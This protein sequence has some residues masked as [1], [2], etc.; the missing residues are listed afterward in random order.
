LGD[1]G[2][3][4]NTET[5]AIPSR[6][7]I[8]FIAVLIA[9]S[10]FGVNNCD[11]SGDPPTTLSMEP[12]SSCV[13]IGQSCTLSVMVDDAVDSLSCVFCVVSFDPE[14]VS[15]TAAREG[16]LYKQAPHPTFFNWELVAP[17]SVRLEDCVLGY[18]TYILAPG[19]LYILVFE[20]IQ[21][22][23]S[24]VTIE[25]AEVYD[26]D[27][28]RLAEDIGASA[29]IWV[30]PTAGAGGDD[31]PGGGPRRGSLDCYPNPFGPVTTLTFSAPC[32]RGVS[33]NGVGEL[34]ICSIAGGL[35]RKLYRGPISD[36]MNVF[37]WNGKNDAGRN[38]PA[39]VYVAVMKTDGS[40][41]KHKLVLT[42]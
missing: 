33:A 6:T 30:N 20:G 12:L 11:C 28:V 36:G 23:A 10:T 26:I 32:G 16:E 18:R 27:R 8:M 25:R 9:M 17:D 29:V 21:G 2:A 7:T 24:P 3:V 15:C 40:D 1:A 39:G 34:L 31:P 5:T 22:G 37:S 38:V 41:F 35:V 42:R 19:E 4:N 14:V 13:N